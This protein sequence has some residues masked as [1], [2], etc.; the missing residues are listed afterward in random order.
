MTTIEITVSPLCRMTF[1][2]N[3]GSKTPDPEDH[4]NK[5]VAK[6]L[7]EKLVADFV[8]KKMAMEKELEHLRDSIQAQM[9]AA[10]EAADSNIK[11]LEAIVEKLLAEQR[12]ASDSIGQLN[13]QAML[14]EEMKSSLEQQV[15]LEE[16]KLQ[17]LQLRTLAEEQGSSRRVAQ[18]QQE[19]L[20]R[21][22]KMASLAAEISQKERVLRAL[23]AMLNSAEGRIANAGKMEKLQQDV[24]LAGI[25]CRRY[26]F[27]SAVLCVAV[28]MCITM[29]AVL[30]T[31][32]TVRDYLLGPAA[33]A[34][35]DGSMGKALVPYY[36]PK[37]TC[38]VLQHC[39]AAPTSSLGSLAVDM[40][41][42]LLFASE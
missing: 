10:G 31:P 8:A 40:L 34:I 38:A 9:I 7:E 12:V 18:L 11:A 16:G 42:D 15:E 21:E 33:G 14:L 37:L 24:K 4:H 28:A 32:S 35:A 41:L 3:C 19:I 2:S 27:A 20:G 1:K 30:H 6:D 13:Q 5:K 39:P 29:F 23:N 22:S 17:A 36:S 25:Q 26:R